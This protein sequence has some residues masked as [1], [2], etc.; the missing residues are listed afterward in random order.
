MKTRSNKWTMGLGLAVWAWALLSV[1][2]QVKSDEATLAAESE[3]FCASTQPDRPT[4]PDV[5]IKKVNEACA[6][7]E[8]EGPAAYPKFKGT[9]SAFIYEGTYIWIHRLSDA[10]MLMHP[11][12]NQMV[13]NKLIGLKDAKGKRF[14]TAMNALVKEKGEGWV[15]YYWPKPGTEDSTRKISFVKKCKMSDGVEVVVGSGIYNASE[16]DLAKLEL[17]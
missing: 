11:I 13:G 8:K 2:P 4:P 14:F 3:K 6:L 7:L 16:A 17:H 15:E 9:G 5:I 10:E 12:K 1:V